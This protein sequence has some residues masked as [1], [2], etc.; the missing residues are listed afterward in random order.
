MESRILHASWIVDAGIMV[1]SGTELYISVQNFTVVR[2]EIKKKLIFKGEVSLSRFTS[3]LDKVKIALCSITLSA[4][5]QP[6]QRSNVTGKPRPPLPAPPAF[7]DGSCDR[8][9]TVNHSSPSHPLE[10]P[11]GLGARGCA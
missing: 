1:R 7:G 8:Q 5:I 10:E 2:F 4:A 3:L 9:S 11:E 6:I